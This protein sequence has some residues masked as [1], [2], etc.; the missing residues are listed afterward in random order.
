M[1]PL[2]LEKMCPILFLHLK[3]IDL[4]FNVQY[5]Y[6]PMFFCRRARI[7]LFNTYSQ[8]SAAHCPYE[9]LACYTVIFSDPMGIISTYSGIPTTHLWPGDTLQV[10]NWNIDDDDSAKQAASKAFVDVFKLVSEIKSS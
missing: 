8:P 9:G 2:Q 1:R 6:R 3:H 10:P 5:L 4:C 7:R